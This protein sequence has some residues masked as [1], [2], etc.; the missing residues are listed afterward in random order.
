MRI[1]TW[2]LEG[3]WDDQTRRFLEDLACDVLLLTEVRRDVVLAS[4]SGH[5]S[6]AEMTLGRSAR[7]GHGSGRPTDA[8]DASPQRVERDQL[9]RGAPGRDLSSEQ[10]AGQRA[11]RDAPHAVPAGD[12]DPRFGGRSDE[13]EPVGGAR[14]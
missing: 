8:L 3:R 12:E 2:N 6:A 7:S 14:A 13:W 1:G 9:G 5:L 4:M 10:L 11:E